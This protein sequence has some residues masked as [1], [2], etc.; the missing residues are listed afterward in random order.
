[1]TK[2]DFKEKID[3]ELSMIVFNEE[4]R[5]SIKTKVGQKKHPNLLKKLAACVAIMALGSTTVFAGYY[6][7][8]KISINDIVLPELD[9]MK[10]IITNEVEG[11]ADEYGRVEKEVGDYNEIKQELGLHLLNSELSTDNPYMQTRIC[12]DNRDFIIITADNFI[13][14]DTSNFQYDGQEKRYAYD[15]GVQYYSPISLSVD[16]ILSENQLNNGWD[17]DYLGM[18]KFVENYTSAQGYKVNIIEDMIDKETKENYVSEKCAVLVADGIRY[19]IKGHVSV[20]T[21][22]SI[23]DT[24]K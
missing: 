21:V 9:H 17:T 4:I 11:T 18:Y 7:V 2:N 5:N 13:L 22:K 10:V 19:T 15:H 24:L 12:T 6:I 16:I 3:D 1:M 14:G 23:I 20:D 8:N